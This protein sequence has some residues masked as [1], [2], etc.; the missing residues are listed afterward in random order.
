MSQGVSVADREAGV[1]ARDDVGLR[2]VR[3]GQSMARL[4]WT[5][6]RRH[7]LATISLLVLAVLGLVAFVAPLFV[8]EEAANRLVVTSILKPPSLT[9][10]FGTDDVGRDVFLRSIFGGPHLA[11]DRLP[12]RPVERDDRGDGRRRQ[13]LSPG[14]DRQQLDAIH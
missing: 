1:A 9:Y 13:R 3:A 5:R 10:P 8:S 12:R 2:R 4:V 7:R 11:P 6:F 14:V